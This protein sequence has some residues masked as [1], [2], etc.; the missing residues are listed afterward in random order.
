MAEHSMTVN[1]N[2]KPTELD[3]LK[4]AKFMKLSM[5]KCKQI[6]EEVKKVLSN[7]I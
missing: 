4:V 3:L 2:G 1:G 7:V 6:I 5:S